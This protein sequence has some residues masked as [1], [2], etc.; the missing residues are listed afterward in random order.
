MSLQLLTDTTKPPLARGRPCVMVVAAEPGEHLRRCIHSVLAHTGPDVPT[1]AVAT[2]REAGN[3]LQ[4]LLAGREHARSVWLAPATAGCSASAGGTI[5]SQPS[6]GPAGGTRLVNRALAL[7]SPADVAIL[8]TPCLLTSGWLE[9]L[10]NAARADSNI[11]TASAFADSG[12]ALAPWDHT[13][14][15]SEDLSTLAD[16]LAEHTLVLRPR[17]NLAV[18]PCVYVRREALELAGDLDADLDLRWALE[19]DFAQR[20]LRY[21]LCHVAADDVLVRPLGS[22]ASPEAPPQELL[23]R[24]TDLGTRPALAASSALPRALRAA[25]SGHSLDVTIDARA[26][27]ATVTGTQRHILELIAAL[28]ATG[29]LRLRLVVSPDAGVEN[30]ELL[31]SLPGTEVLPIESV[32]AATQPTTIFH[33]P[34]QVFATPDLLL[35]MRLGER[36]VLNQLDL[37]AYRNPAYHADAVAWRSHR[38]MSRQGL[39]A[40]D[41][42]VVF[43]EHTRLDLLSDELAEDERIRIV[44]PGLDH[45]LAGGTEGPGRRP[46]AMTEVVERSGATGVSEFLFCLGTDFHHKNRQFALQLLD[47]LRERHAWCGSLVFAGTHIPHGSSVQQEREL[48][49]THPRV[50]DAVIDLG[51]VDDDEKGWL[52]SHAA[53]VV[54]PSVYE[55]FGLVPFEAALSGVPCLFAPQASLA[56]VLPVDAAAIVPWDPTQSADKAHVLL[57]DP[58]ARARHVEKLVK[59][60]RR[61]TWA[62]AVAT[63]VEIYGEAAVAPVREAATL[64]RDEV[65]REHELRELVAAHESRVSSIVSTLSAEREHARKMYDELNAEV[66]FALSLI[67]PNG[68]LPEDLQRAMLALS[69]RPT[70]SRPLYGAA[71]SVFR[72]ARR[73]RRAPHGRVGKSASQLPGPDG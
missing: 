54:Y 66:G 61:F 35:A 7:L 17:L 71:A 42:I 18:G 1:V 62:G 21:G 29:E 3:D 19:T 72:V 24:Y 63:M 34:Q 30:V 50:R 20:C 5:P 38:R 59:S 32:D 15:A 60:A 25:R 12:T 57:T 28:A 46:A 2:T 45:T 58:H 39:A 64:S 6:A 43:S 41:R 22:R 16:E 31:R 9:R 8:S 49:R 33:R 26:L 44:P 65:A 23:R 56:E 73:I 36:I 11:A 37:I 68:T 70:L 13:P 48:I 52:M 14:T 69:A 4:K 47:S 55:G 53:A 51:A 67:G 27:G 40:A 10:R